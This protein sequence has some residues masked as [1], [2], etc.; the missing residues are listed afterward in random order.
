MLR[1]HGVGGKFVEF[2]ECKRKFSAPQKVVSILGDEEKRAL[3]DQTGC[4]DDYV[5]KDANFTTL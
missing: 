2:H 1:K 5:S 3:Y 4:V